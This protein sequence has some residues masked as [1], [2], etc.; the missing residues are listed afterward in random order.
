[1]NK[2]N[3]TNLPASVHHRLLHLAQETKRP[4]NELLQYY[5]MERFLFRLSQSPFADRF[6]LKGALM[7]RVWDL[8]Q[9]RPTMDIDLL[10]RTANTVE[11]LVEI[12][13]Q[14][15]LVE[16]AAD[17]I[18]FDPESVLGEPIALAKKYQGVRVRVRGALGNA[19]VALQLDCGF[20]DVVVPGPVW[21][22]YPQLLDFE[23]PHLLVYTPESVIAEKF[24]ALVELELANTRLKDFFDLWKLSQTLTFDSEILLQAITATFKQRGTPLPITVP[25][26]LT[27][28]FYED[29]QRQAQWNGFIRR[30][31]LEVEAKSLAETATAIAEFLLP[32]T[33]A[34][35]TNSLFKNHWLPGG[36]WQ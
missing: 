20:G 34:A 35:A 30:G 16:V 9:A 21:I 4:F 10:G 24:Q 7:L 18:Q 29:A 19:R 11:H 13:R 5:A 15:L 17:G 25:L 6:I 27:E 26:A 33:Q 1:M 32:L 31:R 23:P 22:D 3:I 8:S 2:R 14:C 28:A 12:S 36:N